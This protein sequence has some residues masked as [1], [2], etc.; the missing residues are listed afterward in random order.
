M[1]TQNEI[2][3][4]QETLPI[5]HNLG[6][7]ISIGNNLILNS[8][9]ERLKRFFSNH[10]EFFIDFISLY[11]P[12]NDYFLTENF[13]NWKLLSKNKNF[14]PNT[15][16]IIRNIDKWNWDDF[17]KNELIEWNF[18]FIEKVK[19]KLN[20]SNFIKN[21][22]FTVAHV[23]KFKKDIGKYKIELCRRR[24]LEWTE[25]FIEKNKNYFNWKYLSYN[26]GICYTKELIE[27]YIDNW[28]W[29][30]LSQNK[31]IPFNLELLI[32]FEDK[33][34]WR[35]LSENT[36]LP[37]TINLIYKFIN[38]WDWVELSKNPSIPLNFDFLEIFINY[39]DWKT[40]SRNE[41]LVWNINYIEKFKDKIKWEFFSLNPKLPFTY[42]LID[43]YINRWYWKNIC[44]NQGVVFD[45]QMIEKYKDYWGLEQLRFVDNPSNNFNPPK[46]DIRCI[47][48]T[49]E[50]VYIDFDFEFSIPLNLDKSRWYYLSK[51]P[52]LPWSENLI[53]KYIDLWNWNGLCQNPNLPW[54]IN[55]V[56]KYINKDNFNFF[57]FKNQNFP[58]CEELLDYFKDLIN[59]ELFIPRANLLWTEKL[60]NKYNNFFT[61]EVLD[62][63]TVNA[64]IT[65]TKELIFHFREKWNWSDLSKR[66]P[67]T[68]DFLE[69]FENYWNWELLLKNNFLI[70][71][72]NDLIDDDVIEEILYLTNL[73][74]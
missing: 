47:F 58:W 43:K 5:L 12:L 40:I 66:L 32:K 19:S 20:W 38:K 26:T 2:V 35:K 10:K 48:G 34:S 30:F 50:R 27:R 13:W 60:M 6:L 15:V 49:A 68:L 7:K 33:W 65:L 61:Q 29:Y 45:L 74:Y 71:P 28:D 63:L 57:I 73:K 55:F 46:D 17:S 44:I 42:E 9:K 23:E 53:D 18:D 56:K 3:K 22:S 21:K 64:Y 8:K 69:T 25:E 4:I 39:V 54:S 62:T 1:E 51:N 72:I 67:I 59:W 16:T 52:N 70:D 36:T 24:D 37:F 31:E 14:N 41:N 11:Y